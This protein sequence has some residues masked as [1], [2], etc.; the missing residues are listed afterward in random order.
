MQVVNVTEQRPAL[1]TALR[2][3]RGESVLVDGIDVMPEVLSTQGRVSD[4]V[5]AVL[6]GRHRGATG[7]RITD[8]VVIGIGGSDLGPRMVTAATRVHHTGDV[9][10]HFVANVDPAELDAV[11]PALAPTTTLVVVI[12]KTF[13]TVETLANARAARSW[14]LSAMSEGDLVHHLCAVTTAVDQATAF[15]VS[16]DALF[17][18][19]DWVGGRY[20]L[21]SPVG[22]GIELALGRS[23]M[24]GLRDGMHAVDVTLHQLP[25]VTES[26]SAAR[27]ARRLV[28]GAFRYDFEGSRP[29]RA[30]SRAASRSSAA[31]ADGEQRQVASPRPVS[32]WAGPPRP[33]SGGRPA[34]T[35]SM[36][37]S[38]CCTRARTWSRSISSASA[39]SAATSGAACS[40]PTC[41]LRR[42][43]S[44]SG[45]PADD[46][47][48]AG[49]DPALVPHKAMPG[50]RPST[51]IWLP[52][53]TPYSVG[54][55]I[56]LYEHATAIAGFAWGIDPFDQWGV[57]RGK[58]LASAL[59]PA[60]QGGSVPAGTDAATRASLRML[61]P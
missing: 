25:R 17:G 13:T 33:W 12:S 3:P 30:G 2:T 56:A 38:S 46:L 49:V 42:P 19:W 18:F 15:G 37:S 52:D 29:L 55:L 16:P 41:S 47:R 24:Q 7:E 11:L 40:R 8:A 31:A 54:A 22:I 23:G 5:E 28:L 4:F 10:V 51:L 44:L 48:R 36:R 53:L 20:S 14:L 43:R 35:G 50:N 21:S 45:R 60:V 27:H 61:G 59:L 39:R 26:R 9:R 34:P 1:H 58:E 6:S 57:E 32:R